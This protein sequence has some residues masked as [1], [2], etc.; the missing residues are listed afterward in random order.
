MNK[1][2]FEDIPN[3]FTDEHGDG[4]RVSYVDDKG[5]TCYVELYLCESGCMVI[6]KDEDVK[7]TF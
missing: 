6:G 2:K 5:V 4:L 7:Y 3:P 1:L